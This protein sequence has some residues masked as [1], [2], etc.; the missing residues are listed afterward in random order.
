M[1]DLL[2]DCVQEEQ[3]FLFSEVVNEHI[4]GS[5]GEFAEDWRDVTKVW[6]AWAGRS[7]WLSSRLASLLRP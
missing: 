7:A 3:F 5:T 4:C 1:E 2:R 6:V